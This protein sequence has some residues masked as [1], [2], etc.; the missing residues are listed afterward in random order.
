VKPTREDALATL[1]LARGPAIVVVVY[2]ILRAV[3]D[4]L[5][6][7]GGLISPSGDVSPGVALLGVLVL[8]LR[9]VVLFVVPA[10]LTYRVALRVIRGPKND[11]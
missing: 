5:T 4:G 7:R 2:L 8:V 3:F 1:R 11:P 6:E 10:V 9:L